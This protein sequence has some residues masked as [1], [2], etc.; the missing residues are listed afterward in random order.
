MSA[1]NFFRRPIASANSL[2]TTGELIKTIQKQ[3]D[4]LKQQ[5]AAQKTSLATIRKQEAA[6]KELN[7]QQTE[8]KKYIL[9]EFKSQAQKQEE[10]SKG[11]QDITNKVTANVHK[12]RLPSEI[13]V[14]LC[15]C[16]L[17]IG[18]VRVM[19]T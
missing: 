19:C 4:K 18:V 14:S 12:R 2:P 3:D 15:I 13:T 7:H 10:I 9:T 8:L 1:G 16:T 17:S 6:I 11:L 5:E